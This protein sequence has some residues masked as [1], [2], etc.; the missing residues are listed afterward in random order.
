MTA[1]DDIPAAKRQ[2]VDAARAHQR[3]EARA[4]E[5][6]ITSR[7]PALP[8]TAGRGLWRATPRAARWLERRR[9]IAHYQRDDGDGLATI[10]AWNAIFSLLPFLLI[11]F[12]LLSL[13][14]ANAAIN[15]QIRQW[16]IELLP[17]GAAKTVLDIVQGGRENLRE[18]GLVALISTLFGGARLFSSLDRAFATIYRIPRRSFL[19][20]KLAAIIMAPF[21]ALLMI[22]GA[23]AATLGTIM[24]AI[25]DR[26][27]SSSD[28]RWISGALTYLLSF[29]VAF[30]MAW[31]IYRIVPQR[32]ECHA[33]PGAA[34]AALL[35][36][37]L[38]QLF[39]I[40]IRLF[41]GGSVYGGVFAFTLVLMLWFYLLGQIIVIGAEVNSIASGRKDDVDTAP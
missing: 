38:G 7:L 28:A 34:V 16:V 11:L 15:N 13:L 33:A 1:T 35:F 4:V 41:G 2:P 25:P 5:R 20:S 8:T 22:G 24:V 37:L 31:I 36:V 39:P 30:A 23:A 12:T 10:I 18:I 29:L 17:P 40:Y 6:Q 32:L 14:V 19:Q 9:L 21:V 26:L 3:R 27:F